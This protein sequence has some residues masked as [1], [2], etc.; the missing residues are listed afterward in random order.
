MRNFL[1]SYKTVAH[2][3]QALYV[4]HAWLCRYKAGQTAPEAAAGEARKIRGEV[5]E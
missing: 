1:I 5:Y 3:R 4:C 2:D